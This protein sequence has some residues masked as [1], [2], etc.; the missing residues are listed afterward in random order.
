MSIFLAEGV[1]GSN[2]HCQKVS[3]VPK[4]IPNR[5]YDHPTH[6]LEKFSFRTE[7]HQIL[8]I[9]VKNRWFF[10]FGGIFWHRR[11]FYE[12]G[13]FFSELQICSRI[14]DFFFIS[15]EAKLQKIE[16]IRTPPPKTPVL[17]GGLPYKRVKFLGMS[18]HVEDFNLQTNNNAPCFFSFPNC[19]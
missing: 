16:P 1:G 4:D 12:S 3:L 8:V 13:N 14:P 19:N 15:I 7:Y 9:L 17:G 5:W 2:Q 10:S 18:S 11:I 6:I